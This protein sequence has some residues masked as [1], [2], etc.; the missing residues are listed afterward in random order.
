MTEAHEDERILEVRDE[1]SSAVVRLGPKGEDAILSVP[2]RQAAYRECDG[3]RAVPR[4]R[5]LDAMMSAEEE[6]GLGEGLADDEEA[7]EEA[8]DG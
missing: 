7:E 8:E 3:T 1:R 5:C 4:T 6:L 2:D